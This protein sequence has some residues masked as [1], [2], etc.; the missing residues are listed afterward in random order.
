MIEF[1]HIQKQYGHSGIALDDL[2]VKIDAG[3]FIY[4][5][6]PSGAGKTTF[7]KL[8]YGAEKPT[9]GQLLLNKVNVTRQGNKGVAA[10]RR[11]LGII[12]QDFKLIHSRTLLENVSLPLQIAGFSQ[13]DGTKEAYRALQDVGLADKRERYPLELSGGEQQ[14]A[15]IARA[16]V[17]KPKLILA[18]EP[19]GNLDDGVADTIIKHLL[20]ANDTG[21]TVIMATH[22]RRLLDRY[23]Q[24]E[25]SLNAGKLIADSQGGR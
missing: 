24:R 9:K 7:L 2:T 22:S 18:D 12:F 17:A 10:M 16:L 1:H 15:A 6:G 5:T 21:A 11:S 19:T 3:E 13:K 20:Q 4:L 14:R 8:L 25:L 23:P